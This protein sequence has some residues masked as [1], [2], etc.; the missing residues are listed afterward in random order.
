MKKNLSVIFSM[1]LLFSLSALAQVTFQKAY[2]LGSDDY[3]NMSTVNA[4]GEIVSAGSSDYAGAGGYDAILTK[5]DVN[6]NFLWEKQYGGSGTEF[7]TAVAASYSGSGYAVAGRSNSFTSGTLDIAIVKTDNDGNMQWSKTYGTD[8]TE[9]AVFISAT[10]DNG[11]IVTGQTQSLGNGGSD[12]FLVK[13]DSTGEVQ[14]FKTYGSSGNEAGF[15]VVQDSDGGYIAVGSSDSGGSGL[16]DAYLVKTDSSGNLQGQLLIGGTG[17]DAARR[18]LLT[19]SGIGILTGITRPTIAN[20]QDDIFVTAIDFDNGLSV[21]WSNTYGNSAGNDAPTNIVPFPDGSGYIFSGNSGSFGAPAGLLFLID[22]NGVYQAG[23]VYQ[24][25]GDVFFQDLFIGSTG[26]VLTGFGNGFGGAASDLYLIEFPGDPQQTCLRQDVLLSTTSFPVT[27]IGPVIATHNA[28]SISNPAVSVNFTQA[29]ASATETDV[30]SNL[31]LAAH[32][33]N[34]QTTCAGGSGVQLGA[35]PPAEGGTA[36]YAYSWSPAAGLSS[37]TDP[38]PFASPS[39]ATTYTLT[40]TDSL[41]ATATD[42]VTV[43]IGGGPAAAINPS[44]P[45]ICFNN[46]VTLTA[47]GGVSYSWSTGDTTAQIVKN[48]TQ[49]VTPYS[50]TVTDANGCTAVATDTVRMYNYPDVNATPASATICDTSTTGVTLTASG[51]DTYVWT[52]STGLSDDSVAAPVAT[53]AVTT[54]Y[55][56]TGKIAHCTGPNATATVTVTV[57]QCVGI[58]GMPQSFANIFPNPASNEVNI[59]FDAPVASEGVLSILAVDG[60]VE[61]E[62]RIAISNGVNYFSVSTAT[63]SSGLHFVKIKTSN[64]SA[65]AK[66]IV[67]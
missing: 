62:E 51:A 67:E 4:N 59:V 10:N 14:W 35:N 64:V 41:G 43:S 47:S 15:H 56:V 24:G 61:Y 65:V 33:G 53:P 42:Q 50:V 58:A 40:V 32:A 27:I 17:D 20:S 34:D 60:R 44:G 25:Q 13:V 11:Y 45:N 36:P 52:P 31:P 8:S 6:G 12:L 18:I 30:C 21:L 38:H 54:T 39:S 9:Y 48:P 55:T 63:L 46:N 7:G 26:A 66:V 1:I 22:T 23:L 19:S 5:V 37:V 29:S 2:D 16:T 28:V 57:E 3:I 49:E